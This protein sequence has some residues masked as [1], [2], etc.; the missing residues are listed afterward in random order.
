MHIRRFSN[1][2][3]VKGLDVTEEEIKRDKADNRTL[4]DECSR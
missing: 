1:A 2:L 3:W 4:A